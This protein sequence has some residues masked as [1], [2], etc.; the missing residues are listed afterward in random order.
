MKMKIGVVNV[1]SNDLLEAVGYLALQRR[2]LEKTLGPDVEIVVESG[3]NGGLETWSEVLFNP[4]FSSLDGKKILEKLYKLQKMGC[5]GVIISCT[6]DPLLN[7][8]RALLRIPIVGTVEAS[9]FSACM[10]GQKFGFLIFPERRVAEITEAM[11][12]RYGLL[13]RMAPMVDA[14]ERLEA[15]MMEAF[16]DPELA[17]EELTKGC[18]E[19]IEKGAHS[20][21]LGGTSF[22]NI[23]TALGISQVPEYGAPIFDPI[24]V[25]AE[26]LRYRIGLERSLGI[27]P[28]SH[29]GTFR[30][31]PA[32]FEQPVMKSLGFAC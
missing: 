4:F 6:Q 20:V 3:E 32:E 24:C 23:A 30:R 31:F 16:K 13:S 10:A 26:M 22:S 15:V 12:A 29:A 8:A 14:S 1:V 9:I 17:R 11:V 18:R 19:V 28:V 27:P 7:E 25:G 5:D 21:I 2:N